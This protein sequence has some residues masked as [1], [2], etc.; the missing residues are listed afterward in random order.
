MAY[1]AN[2]QEV[3][4]IEHLDNGKYLV[5]PIFG[6]MPQDEFVFIVDAIFKKDGLKALYDEE[7][8]RRYLAIQDLKQQQQQLERENYKLESTQNEIRNKVIIMTETMTHYLRDA[9]AH[10][11]VAEQYAENETTKA[12]LKQVIELLI[13]A[14]ANKTAVYEGKV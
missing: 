2:G 10:L 4:L 8:S 7:I 1:L 14:E 3:E 9:M 11:T 5:C 6:G 13:Q 12:R